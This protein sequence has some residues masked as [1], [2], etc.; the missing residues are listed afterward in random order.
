MHESWN[1]AKNREMD[2]HITSLE[3]RASTMH[4]EPLQASIS[5]RVADNMEPIYIVSNVSLKDYIINPCCM[6]RVNDSELLFENYTHEDIYFFCNELRRRNVDVSYRLKETVDAPM[7]LEILGLSVDIL[8]LILTLVEMR[9]RD[10][11][12]LVVK[13]MLPDGN[14]YEANKQNIEALSGK[15]PSPR[16]EIIS[17][18]IPS[19]RPIITSA[20]LQFIETELLQ[21]ARTLVGKPIYLN[22]RMLDTYFNRISY[23]EFNDKMSAIVVDLTIEDPRTNKLIKEG[24]IVGSCLG[25]IARQVMKIDENIQLRGIRFDELILRTGDYS[26]PI[27]FLTEQLRFRTPIIEFI[28]IVK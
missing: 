2:E 25:G 18:K 28:L 10:N 17:Y 20:R 15:L 8:M 16:G 5:T 7:T 21:S 4:V 13:I 3:A 27:D 19:L 24:R 9:K 11:P 6:N 12:N 22:D 1:N 26:L 14:V 23:S